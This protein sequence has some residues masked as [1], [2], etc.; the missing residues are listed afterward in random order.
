MKYEDAIRQLRSTQ[1]TVYAFREL[2]VDDAR[3]Q[4]EKF[5]RAPDEN[6]PYAVLVPAVY[7]GAGSYNSTSTD[8]R[9]TDWKVSE[10]RPM[11]S[12]F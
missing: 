1:K 6:T 5:K 4:A 11:F 7:M 12:V 10:Y 8:R 9:A 3:E 2:W